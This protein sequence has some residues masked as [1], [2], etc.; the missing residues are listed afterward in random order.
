M[1]DQKSILVEATSVAKE[2]VGYVEEEI[3]EVVNDDV[4]FDG[5]RL[6]NEGRIEQGKSPKLTRPGTVKN[7]A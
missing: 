6:R 3:G 5:R 7:K 1:S 2:F 4:A